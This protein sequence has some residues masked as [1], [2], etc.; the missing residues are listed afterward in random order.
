MVDVVNRR[1]LGQVVLQDV[2]DPHNVGA[3]MRSC[4]AFGIQDLSIIF[5]NQKP[6]NARRLG[7]TSTAAHKWLNVTPYHS[8][9]ECLAALRTGGYEIVAAVASE[10]AESIYEAEFTA[11]KIALLIGNEKDGLDE[12]AVEAADRHIT[13][14]MRGMVRSFNLSVATAILLYELTR[15]RQSHA[16][17]DY[18]LPIEQRARLEKEFLARAENKHIRALQRKRELRGE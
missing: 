15:Q 7:A 18:R 4:E 5:E 3:V 9:A 1:Q 16:G 11:P 10:R 8:T 2:H 6:F 13:I 14:P 12:A 17:V